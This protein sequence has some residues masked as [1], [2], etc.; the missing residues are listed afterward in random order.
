MQ[1]FSLQIF[2]LLWYT[3]SLGHAYTK[4]NKY[5]LDI[6]VV[7]VLFDSPM[8]TTIIFSILSLYI[9]L[10]VG[11]SFAVPM[12][13]T[14]LG[15]VLWSQGI[16]H[17]IRMMPSF[18]SYIENEANAPHVRDGFLMMFIYLPAIF[19][20]QFSAFISQVLSCILKVIFDKLKF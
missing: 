18:I 7:I 5:H 17:L 14:G 20:E 11:D 8:Q 10:Y 16:D 3:L 2:P 4:Y 6:T 13:F 1:N 12:H 9:L 19:K 15:E